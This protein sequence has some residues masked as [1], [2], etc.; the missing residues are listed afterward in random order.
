[1]RLAFAMLAGWVSGG[2]MPQTNHPKDFISV[3]DWPA[4]ALRE[5][6]ARASELKRLRASRVPRETLRGRSVVLYFEKPSLRTYVTFGV[7]VSELGGYPVYLPPGQV[8]LGDREPVEDVARNLSRWCD[9]IVAR[10]YAHDLV[11]RLA[12]HAS[13]PVIN[14]LTDHLHPCQVL[15]DALT[16]LEQEADP[17]RDRLVYL[18]DGNNMA[19]SLLHLV[20]ALGWSITLCTPPSHAPDPVVVQRARE[21]ARETGAQIELAEDPAAA[22]KGARFVY[23]DTWTSMGQEAQAAQR[24]AVFRPYQVNAALLADASRDVQVLHCLPAHR[25]EEITA[26]VLESP[27]SLVF[28]QAENRLHAQKAILEILLAG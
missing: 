4:E 9:G 24:S 1:M 3:A 17:R 22:V 13:V 15:A 6:L 21:R 7:G 10:T 14:A 19:H 28:E 11:E 2:D 8:G 18:G 20:A 16:V 27:R 23:T 25:G 12:E 26:D 5:L